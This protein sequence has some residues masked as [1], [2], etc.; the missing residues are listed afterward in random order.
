MGTSET[1]AERGVV[2]IEGDPPPMLS[3]VVPAF[4]EAARIG[5]SIRKIDAFMRES[6]FSFELIVVD[7]GSGDNTTAI[8]RGAQAKD[9]RLL[10][11]EQNH[12]N[13]R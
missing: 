9:L 13:H 5:D 2:P 12:G 4:N 11:N 3:I 6:P 10:R 7:D 8:V 1:S